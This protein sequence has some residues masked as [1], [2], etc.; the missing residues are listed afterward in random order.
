MGTGNLSGIWDLCCSVQVKGGRGGQLQ[1]EFQL[2]LQFFFLCSW[3]LETHE[4]LV[5]GMSGYLRHP[6]KNVK[7]VKITWNISNNND[8][9][10]F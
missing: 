9:C 2:F 7:P 4:H 6:Q 5:F 1:G 10:V 3:V 8:L